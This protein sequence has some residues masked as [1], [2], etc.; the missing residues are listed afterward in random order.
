MQQVK[1][2]A[3]PLQRLGSLLCH[4][5]DLWPGNFHMPWAWHV[6]KKKVKGSKKIEHANINQKKEDGAILISDKV[7]F[8]AKQLPGTERGII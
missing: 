7:D 2:L 8:R 1:D 5:F 3:L 6:G 4:R